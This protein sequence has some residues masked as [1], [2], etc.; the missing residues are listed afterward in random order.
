[1]QVGPVAFGRRVRVCAREGGVLSQEVAVAVMSGTASPV[2]LR[3]MSVDEVGV[4]VGGLGRLVAGG[5]AAPASV[6]LS[7]A[8]QV[9]HWIGFRAVGIEVVAGVPLPRVVVVG[10]G[11]DGTCPAD[12]WVEA[13]TSVPDGEVTRTDV[14]LADAD[15]DGG[16]PCWP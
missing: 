10:G 1:M 2:D 11:A 7:G 13:A 16:G 4:L 6:R 12:G 14:W 5:M 8:A 3:T 9:A 15:G